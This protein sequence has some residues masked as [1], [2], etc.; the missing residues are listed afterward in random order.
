MAPRTGPNFLVLA[1]AVL[2]LVAPIL[3]VRVVPVMLQVMACAR[4][5]TTYVVRLVGKVSGTHSPLGALVIRYNVVTRAVAA[6]GR[7]AYTRAGSVALVAASVGAVNLGAVD[8]GDKV[9]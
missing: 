2:L 6:R 3:A 4:R 8:S 1:L 7:L 5:S 9:S